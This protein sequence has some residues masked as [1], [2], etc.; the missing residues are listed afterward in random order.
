MGAGNRSATEDTPAGRDRNDLGAWIASAVDPVI[1]DVRQSLTSHQRAD[2]HWLFELESDA[3]ISAE[4]ILLGHF[5]DEIDDETDQ[6][7]AGYLREIQCDHG[8]PFHEDIPPGARHR[9]RMH[10]GF[11]RHAGRQVQ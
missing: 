5:L 3:T 11:Q 9:R 1:A 10:P 8:A 6:R 4:Y 2:G 7:L